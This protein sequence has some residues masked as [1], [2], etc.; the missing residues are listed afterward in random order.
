MMQ[1][2]AGILYKSEYFG[3]EKMIDHIVGKR[4]NLSNTEK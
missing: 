2:M 3:L 1:S 4:S